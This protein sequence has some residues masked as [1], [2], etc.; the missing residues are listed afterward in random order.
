LDGGG[1]KGGL[2]DAAEDHVGEGDL[3][4]KEREGKGRKEEEGGGRGGRRRKE[5]EG[6]GRRKEEGGRRK[7][8]G[9]GLEVCW[10]GEGGKVGLSMLLRTT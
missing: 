10:M 3:E 1:R 7:E 6:G 2:V 5:E 4:G 9:E 8:E